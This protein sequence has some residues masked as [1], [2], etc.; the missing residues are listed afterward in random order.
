MQFRVLGTLE[1]VTG[2]PPVP[3]AVPGGMERAL[4][5]RLL[6][7]PGSVVTV[8][9][10]M[11]DLWDGLPPRTARKS[12]QVHVVRL[13]ST[14]EPERPRGSPGR[15]LVRRGDGYALAVAVEDVDAG[16]A[17]V[18]AASGRAAQAAGDPARAYE[19]LH[20]AESLWRGVPFV[21]WQDAGWARSAR[22]S[23]TSVRRAVLE[24]RLD[25]DLAVGRHRE[26]L[27]E[28]EDLVA[29]DPLA[30]G[31]AT[32]LM[33]ALY[34]SDRQ[35]D[36]L[37]VGRRARTLLVDE[38]G[39]EAGPG[40]RHV[41]EAILT[42][43]AELD[44][45]RPQ[46]EPRPEPPT[47]GQALGCPYL[48]LASYHP[49]DEAVFH[50]RAAAVRALV[51]RTRT[52]VI[53]V[54]SGS[55]GAGKSSLVRA[56]LLPALGRGALPG[57][58]RWRPVVVVPGPRAVDDLAPLLTAEEP[59]D[60]SPPSVVLVVDQLEEIWTSGVPPAERQAFFDALLAL[61][62]DDVCTR[63]VLVVRGDHLGRLGEH[64]AL[65]ARV[66][67]GIV[68][69]PPLTE[70]ELREVVEGP[71]RTCGLTV[72]PDLVDAVLRDVHG[73][74]A[75]LPLLSSALVGTWQR[76]RAHELT[77]A[78]YLEAGGVT[79]ALARSAEDALLALDEDAQA[80]A[81][82]LLLR[83]AATSTTGQA[84]RRRVPVA[85]LDLH[86]AD[87]HLRRQVVE[88]FVSRRL[89][90]IDADSL[91]VT[92]EA[93]LTG[94]PRLVGW[95]VEDAASRAVRTHLAPEARAW[96][97]AGRPVDRLYRG[98]RLSAAQEWA[99]RP[100]A[101]LTAGERDF[102]QHSVALGEAE[103]MEARAQTRR[104]R[105]ARR[106][107]RRLA[108]VL[109]ATVV[110]T[111]GAG[112]MAAQGRRD[113]DLNAAAA[114]LSAVRADADRLAAASA[115][116]SSLDLSM[117]LAAQAYRTSATPQT[118][119]GLLAAVVGHRQVSGVYRTNGLARRI[120]LG[121]DGRTLYAHGE[122]QVVAW[123][124]IT[125]ERMALDSYD[126][127]EAFPTDVDVA[128]SLTGRSGA[129]AETRDTV[130]VVRPR[131]AGAVSSTLRLIDPDGTTR[132]T[133]GEADLGGWPVTAEFSTAGTELVVEIVSGY[134][135]A[136]P[137]GQLVV[138][139]RD[140]GSLS[141]LGP[142]TPFNPNAFYDP[143]VKGISEDGGTALLASLAADGEGHDVGAIDV[144]TGLVTGLEPGAHG[145]RGSSWVPV[146][147]GVV[148]M[149]E[150]GAVYWYP[151]GSTTSTQRLSSHVSRAQAAATDAS[152][153]VL[154]TGGTDRRVVVHDLVDGEWVPREV[155]DGHTGSVREIAVSPDGLRAFSTGED[156]TVIEWDLSD[157]LRFGTVVPRLQDPVSGAFSLFTGPA[158]TAGP[159]GTLV[160]PANSLSSLGPSGET[161][162][163]ALFLDAAPPHAVRDRVRVG[164][165]PVVPIPF[166]AAATSPDG[167]QVAVTAQFSTTILRTDTHDVVTNVELDEVDGT[168]YGFEGR[169][170]EPVAPVTW[171]RDGSQL[172]IGTGGEGRTGA[173][174]PGSVVVVDTTSWDV[175][176]RLPPREAVTALTT[177]PDGR[178]IGIG[179]F[180]GRVTVADAETY[181]VAHELTATGPVAALAFSGDGTRLAAVG[182][183]KALDLWDTTTGQDVLDEPQRFGG[184]GTSVAWLPDDRTVVH[185]GDDGRAVLFDTRLQRVRGVPLPVLRDGG[186]GVVH[187]TP[188]R[189]GSD[190]LTLLPGFRT[191]S[192]VREGMVYPLDVSAWLGHACGV[193]A[194]DLTAT[195]WD[196]YLPDRPYATT[197]ST[198]ERPSTR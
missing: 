187:V 176:D 83:L 29:S 137:V 135:G 132:W 110:A 150:D 157:T 107:T 179:D 164:T 102:V 38:L 160:T 190:D 117:V 47:V 42:Q 25:A 161:W 59:P 143:W 79:G 2:A 17:R 128:R 174:V 72:D 6:A 87:G 67:E 196:T 186:D 85:E 66:A 36:A 16:R 127:D 169:V 170:P 64:A 7:C 89:L 41:E 141:P 167:R 113:A 90:S 71:A 96:E 3:L 26:V 123:D 20:E 51:G 61:L 54:V 158:V 45:G 177:S 119:D 22:E 34:R 97:D 31:W 120:A 43:A 84:V 73:Q 4:L 21:D 184:A 188:P 175:V 138:V 153:R 109:A 193:A 181:E 63:V 178:W 198:L 152:G 39:L 130:A 146:Q 195:E 56:G 189:D 76:R 18:L 182:G 111:L 104:E 156:R 122:G 197:C 68:L 136:Q 74:T 94:W 81:Q 151:D 172:L 183:S 60:T 11:E 168:D 88:T 5:G 12:L 139:D 106:R 108:V 131:E 37:A 133:V 165:R 162:G 65:T 129:G 166:S 23:L 62:D 46:P 77:L 32:R 53:V 99:N 78:G 95:L 173:D 75:A 192:A 114:E 44:P 100:D 134:G 140:D 91:D 33:V 86:S 112:A 92:H 101:D 103:L 58:E 191:G 30:E 40:L 52:A 180:S 144:M 24:A 1:V 49:G 14:L 115:N 98:A 19:L 142:A 69:V 159:S 147:G 55:S 124:L 48:G 8:D 148:E 118:E 50:G 35:A 116:A 163:F 80:V 125:R 13:R 57:S 145:T 194:R 27:G 155:L 185:G 70:P 149:A 28:L 154:V 171:N 82:P 93:L 121:D 9:T 10:L 126:S 15:Y 105:A